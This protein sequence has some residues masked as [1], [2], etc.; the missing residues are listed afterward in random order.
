MA[1]LKHCLMTSS[2][3]QVIECID[4]VTGAVRTGM[5]LPLLTEKSPIVIIVYK[6]SRIKHCSVIVKCGLNSEVPLYIVNLRKI[7]TS[8]VE[9]EVNT[10]R[11]ETDHFAEEVQ[12]QERLVMPMKP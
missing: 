4:D 3:N 7:L 1:V 5:E 10:A 2:Y 6:C 8:Q 12:F 9:G 11:Y